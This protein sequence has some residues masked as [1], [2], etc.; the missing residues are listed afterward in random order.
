M[1]RKL[2]FDMVFYVYW[3]KLP[4]KYYRSILWGVWGHAYF[5]YLGWGSRLWETLLISY[6]HPL[7]SHVDLICW[8]NL[9]MMET[10]PGGWFWSM[11][12]HK[13]IM[14]CFLPLV[15][16]KKIIIYSLASSPPPHHGY[17]G[18]NLVATSWRTIVNTASLRGGQCGNITTFSQTIWD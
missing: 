4:F 6:M 12:D 15:R 11:Q 8:C 1:L 18:R 14:Q 9:W 7:Q 13:L 10:V 3:N 17:L 2:E 5:A 16:E